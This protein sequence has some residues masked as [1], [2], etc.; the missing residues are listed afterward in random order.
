MSAELH[1][2]VGD[3]DPYELPLGG[4][5]IF[6]HQGVPPEPGDPS[7]GSGGASGT[8]GKPSGSGT[9]PA[10]GAPATLKDPTKGRGPYAELIRGEPR[11]FDFDHLVTTFESQGGVDIGVEIPDL[12]HGGVGGREGVFVTV[13]DGLRTTSFGDIKVHLIRSSDLDV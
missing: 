5:N 11:D 2:W 10:T 6:I 7:G 13:L 8:G 9:P 4:V 12:T 3:E 1:V